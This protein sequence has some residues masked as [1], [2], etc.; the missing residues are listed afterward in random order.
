MAAGA[1]AVIA[2]WVGIVVGIASWYASG[3][4]RVRPIIRFAP[5]VLL[6]SVAL[7]IPII[8]R[9]KRFPPFFDWVTHFQWANWA[10]WLAIS[11]LVLDVLISIISGEE[12][13]ATTDQATGLSEPLTAGQFRDPAKEQSQ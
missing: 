8:Q 2:P 9:V 10:V 5:P 12:E 6:I 7:G 13:L 3:G 1:G 11:A 4:R